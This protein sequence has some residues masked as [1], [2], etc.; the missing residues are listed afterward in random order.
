MG[1]L[2]GIVNT[3]KTLISNPIKSFTEGAKAVSAITSNPVVTIKQ[4]VLAGEAK[5]KEQ[6][7]IV[8]SVRSVAT[9]GAVAAAVVGGGAA[10]GSTVA[11]NIISKAVP[12]VASTVKAAI[13][14]SVAGKAAAALVVPVVA[15]AAIKNPSGAVNTVGKILD[16]QVDAGALIADPSLSKAE[17]YLKE[18]PGASVA[19]G[20]GALAA[21]GGGLGLAA[22]TVATYLNSKATNENTNATDPEAPS[23]SLPTDTTTTKTRTVAQETPATSNLAPSSQLPV[24]PQT[25]TI[26]NSP[27]R[28]RSSRRKA[29]QPRVT[30]RVNV[31]VSNKSVGTTTKN[32]IRRGIYA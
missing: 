4:G 17:E 14:K 8:S 9:V 7:A 10:V 24:T 25:Q 31:I 2:S 20:V 15:T 13:P 19:V 27:S 23:A 1:L 21:V 29:I 5:V 26:T 32:Y 16:A 28:K 12:I 3:A 30:Q 6:G 22:N 18:H 11:K